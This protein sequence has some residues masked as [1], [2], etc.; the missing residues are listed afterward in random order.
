[1]SGLPATVRVV[2]EAAIVGYADMTSIYTL[3]TW[4]GGWMIRVVAQ[5]VFFALFGELVEDPDAT[6]FIVV[7]NL[8]VLA[9]MP[10]VMGAV[11]I[12]WD[13]M[14]G[15]L[16]A[17]VATPTSS[18][19]ALAGRVLWPATEGAATAL[20]AAPLALWLFDVPVA[21][22]DVPVL[23]VLLVVTVLSAAGLASFVGAVLLHRTR[24]RNLGSNT[25]IFTM[26]AAC[27]V[28][29][30]LEQTPTVLAAVG[31]VLPLTHGLLAVRA[32]LDG[33]WGI[34]PLMARELATG[35]IWF[36]LSLPMFAY[37]VRV[38]RQRGTLD[39]S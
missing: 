28:N 6:R 16:P 5:V 37:L 15:V 23:V 2:R 25:A 1:M 7:G 24:W 22:T 18:T 39:A 4:F 10:T 3:R 20:L 27:G 19:A 26:M 29:V 9:M 35:A 13:R 38:G 21:L 17:I 31:G 12:T 11:V 34:G 8:L 36:A 30:P 14:K 32:V 33:T